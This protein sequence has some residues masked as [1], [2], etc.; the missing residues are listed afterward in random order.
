M[1]LDH[2]AGCGLYVPPVNDLKQIMVDRRD[3]K[4]TSGL[5]CHILAPVR[6]AYLSEHLEKK[7]NRISAQHVESIVNTNGLRLVPPLGNLLK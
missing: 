2:E 4:P 5:K 1:A 3:V 7:I 6:T